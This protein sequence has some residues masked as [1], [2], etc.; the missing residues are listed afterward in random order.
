METT[1]KSVKAYTDDK[2]MSEAVKALEALYDAINIHVAR[3]YGSPIQLP[4]LVTIQSRGKH[5]AYA[6]VTCGKSW[7]HAGKDFAYELN[8]AA[9]TL[10][11]DFKDTFQT[12]VH[13]MLHLKNIELGIKDCSS[14]SQR[15]NKAFKEACDKIGLYVEQMG[16]YGWCEHSHFESCSEELR[17]VHDY[18]V[19]DC[20]NHVEALTIQRKDYNTPKVKGGKK[21]SNQVKYVCPCCGASVRA[22]SKV[23]IMCADCEEM[24]LPEL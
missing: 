6:W 20:P 24:M 7:E 11:C 17:N 9:E 18:F 21:K 13:E 2:A 15:H 22:T 10:A 14:T 1:V 16:R 19:A 8:V 5:K 4:V 23:N 3:A 12:M